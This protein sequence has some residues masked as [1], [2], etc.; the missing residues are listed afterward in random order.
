[1]RRKKKQIFFPRAFTLDYTPL[2][3]L[4]PLLD[5]SHGGRGDS[6]PRSVAYRTLNFAGYLP[7]LACQFRASHFSNIY[8][9]TVYV[10][11]KTQIV[12]HVYEQFIFNY[13]KNVLKLG[14][15]T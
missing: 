1:M 3:K 8:E 13:S 6:P 12:V 7:Q 15:A 5:F 2:K 4:L 14:L 10:S 11:K 9:N